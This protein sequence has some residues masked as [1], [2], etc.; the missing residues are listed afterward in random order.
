MEK[1]S[2]S[3]RIWLVGGLG[4]RSRA[5]SNLPTHPWTWSTVGT[6]AALS[7]S[8][9]PVRPILPRTSGS[10]VVQKNP[11]VGAHGQACA[12][13]RHERAASPTNNGARERGHFHRS[14]RRRQAKLPH[15]QQNPPK[16]CT[17]LRSCS[18][19]PAGERWMEPLL[20][21]LRRSIFLALILIDCWMVA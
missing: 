9:V 19:S 18:F 15:L 21:F 10:Q 17:V 6:R 4:S 16:G 12:P 20:G 2:R 3:R 13:V 11:V 1:Q 5:L 14:N 8:A 7:F